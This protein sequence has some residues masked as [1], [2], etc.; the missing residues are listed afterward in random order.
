MELKDGGKR[1]VRSV[2]RGGGD[3][4]K[5]KEHVI[6]QIKFDFIISLTTL[7]PLLDVLLHLFKSY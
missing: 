5:Q 6:N 3:D 2:C 7:S 4:G 1:E